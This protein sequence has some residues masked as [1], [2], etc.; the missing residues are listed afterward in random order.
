MS[1][2]ITAKDDRTIRIDGDDGATCT[3][4]FSDG[5]ARLLNLFVPE[6]KRSNGLG[7]ELLS[8]VERHAISLGMTSMVCNFA[9]NDKLES[10]FSGNGFEIGTAEPVLTIDTEA[11]LGSVGVK[12][13]M[14]MTFSDVDTE[15][16]DM[17]LEYEKRDISDMLLSYNFPCERADLDRYIPSLSFVAYD[18]NLK[19]SAILLSSDYEGQLMVSFLI[20]TSAKKPQFILSVCQGLMQAIQQRSLSEIYP[21]IAMLSVNK[22]IMPLLKRL[23][24][25]SV[26]I[27]EEAQTVCATKSL[28]GKGEQLEE[29]L[30]EEYTTGLWKRD[31]RQ[32]LYQQDI[33][34]KYMWMDA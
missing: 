30:N 9:D 31:R 32:P 12:K 4:T 22:K 24:D 14:G 21:K 20:G 8:T 2:Y 18:D 33:N 16:F 15:S 11:I 7:S 29:K 26:S 5:T 10:F 19:P 23:L 28:S 13:T 6:D 1:T 34:D 3:F 17:L 27:D 25:K